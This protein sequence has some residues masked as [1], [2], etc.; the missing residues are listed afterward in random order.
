MCTISGALRLTHINLLYVLSNIES[1]QIRRDRA[2]LQEYKK[3]QQLTDGVPI[4]EI[5][6]ESPKSRLRSRRS[7]VI[8]DARLTSLNQTEQDIQEQSWI[9]GAPPGHDIVT[10]P[11]CPQPGPTLHREV[12]SSL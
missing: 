5:I 12:S 10:D 9:V 3:A 8:E 2:T 6:R 7:F 1:P 11:T 4:K